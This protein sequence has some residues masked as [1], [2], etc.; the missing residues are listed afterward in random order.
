MRNLATNIWIF[1][2]ESVPFL[3]FPFTTRMT[4]IKL[5]NDELWVHSP[6]KLTVTIQ[7]QIQSLGNVKYLIAPN[8]LHHLFLAEWQRMYPQASSYGTDEVIKKRDD[9]T[10]DASL[11][12]DKPWP[13]DENIQQV[14]FSGSPLMQECVFFHRA[15]RV[16]IVTD[17]IEN[18]SGNDFNYWQRMVAKMVGILAPHGK[19][20]LD[21]RLS[22]MFAKSQ[23]RQQLSIIFAWQ[24][25]MVIMSH[26]II[27]EQDA[28]AFLKRSFSWLT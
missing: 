14:L 2:G 8:H 15:E 24:P 12:K 5:S 27:V 25:K 3:G 11:N 18:F 20:P 16:L 13:W 17:L 4:V 10:F 1:E 22:F 19:M 28:H 9:I 23:A 26:G 7:A 21:W 6:I